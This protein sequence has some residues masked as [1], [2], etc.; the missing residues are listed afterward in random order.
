MGIPQDEE[1][2]R[3]GDATDLTFLERLEEQMGNHPHFVTW[4]GSYLLTSHHFSVLALHTGHPPATLVKYNTMPLQTLH[5][6]FSTQVQ[7]R[8]RSVDWQLVSP[9][10]SCSVLNASHSSSLSPS[11]PPTDYRHKLADKMTR[12]TLDRGDFRLLHYAGEVTYCVVGKRNHSPRPI[13][14]ESKSLFFLTHGLMC[15][16][17]VL[18]FG[19]ILGFLD[20]NNDLLYRNIKDVSL[21][22]SMGEL[23]ETRNGAWGA[24]LGPL[25]IKHPV[26][27]L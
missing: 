27:L 22:V 10:E 24:T 4:V 6:P 9:T 23:F 3:P 5:L 18:Y 11:F 12:K 14:S 15:P 25:I 20:K 26:D 17:P 2:L 8:K 19:H 21:D 13:C 16:K 7:I 1:C